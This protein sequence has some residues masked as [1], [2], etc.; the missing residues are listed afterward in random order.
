M[1][2]GEGVGVGGRQVGWGFECAREKGRRK[3]EG[4]KNILFCF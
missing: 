4:R 3:G 2:A 1:H